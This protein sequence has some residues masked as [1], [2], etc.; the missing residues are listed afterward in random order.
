MEKLA[1]SADSSWQTVTPMKVNGSKI[2]RMVSA[3]ICMQ[4]VQATR[5]NGLKTSKMGRD[6]KNGPMEVNIKGRTKMVRS[7]A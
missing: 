2:K 5:A 1:V 7:K 6:L 3:S 4:M